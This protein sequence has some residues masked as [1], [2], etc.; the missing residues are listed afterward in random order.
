[1]GGEQVAADLEDN[2]PPLRDDIRLAVA[3]LGANPAL[4]T[5][6]PPGDLQVGG[7]DRRGTS[8]R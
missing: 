5:P 3:Y 6:E 2:N 8:L 1:M 4:P 7:R